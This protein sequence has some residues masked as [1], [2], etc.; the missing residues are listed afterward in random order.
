MKKG[1]G[2]NNEERCIFETCR[3]RKNDGSFTMV[4][5][6]RAYGCP[7]DDRTC[8]RFGKRNALPN[9]DK[10]TVTTCNK[11]RNKKGVPSTLLKENYFGCP[12]DGKC[13][14]DDET[15]TENCTTYRCEL[16]KGRTMMKWAIIQTGCNT[17]EGCKYDGEEWSDLDAPSC[18]KRRCDVTYDG[19]KYTRSNTVAK[20]G[21]RATSGMCYYDG[22]TWSESD[23]YTRRCEVSETEDGKSMAS[24]KIDSGV[25]KDADGSCKS[26]GESFKYR[27]G[28]EL[29]DCVC[30][31]TTSESGYPQ[32]SPKCAVP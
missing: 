14:T 5:K 8:L 17:E 6:E 1:M 24:T 7:M 3:R 11:R 10:C 12:H 32:G 27:A 16:T 4:Y 26:Y 31:K 20:H 13:M 2:E 18:V 29:L 22:E 19:N 9:P 15:R 25:C 28:S 21:C 30:E 23:C